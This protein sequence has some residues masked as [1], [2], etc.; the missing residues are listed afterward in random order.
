MRLLGCSRAFLLRLTEY[1]IQS[2]SAARSQPGGLQEMGLS[3]KKNSKV[4]EREED[5]APKSC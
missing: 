1:F 4:K 2:D 3:T 5:L